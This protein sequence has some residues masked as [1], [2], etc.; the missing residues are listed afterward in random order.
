LFS[1]KKEK[2]MRHLAAYA[3][4]LLIYVP[5]CEGQIKT[6]QP[7]ADSNS[8]I[9]GVNIYAGPNTIVRNLIQDRNGNIWMASWDGVFKYD[10]KGKFVNVTMGV[11]KA[12][13]FSVLEDRKGNLWF[14]SI[15]SGVYFYDGTNFQHFTTKEG[16][17]NDDVGSIY[18]DKKGNIWFG[19]FG[20]ASR[21]DG[22]SF[23]NFI[24]NG[25]TMNEDRTGKTF[26]D[27]PPYEVT[28]IIEDRAGKFWFATRD[29]T[30]VYDGK[31]FIVC[32]N[33][34]DQPFTNVR[35]IIED[36]KG[37]IWLGGQDGLWRSDQNKALL[38]RVFGSFTSV[39]RN[40]V[41]YIYEDKNG[42]IWTSSENG[43]RGQNWVLSRYEAKSLSDEIPTATEVS[44]GVKMLFGILQVR[45]G[46][47]WV[48]A[49]DGVYRY[50]GITLRRP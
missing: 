3:L 14:G 35:S 40:F 7:K 13:F 48:G 17:L 10:A 37:N 39:T 9:T 4:V 5:A 16:L 19:V 15:G 23:R 43:G 36:T 38:S 47:I 6:E 2:M 46:R 34:I 41:G 18:E 11:S 20:G 8:G 50:D 30:F 45:D 27:R 12:R 42:N 1:N 26:P 31:A 49:L 21:F 28:S 29:N 44:P 32:K 25:E 22:K 24:I 33:D